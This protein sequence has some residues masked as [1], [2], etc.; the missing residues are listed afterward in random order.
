MLCFLSVLVFF[1][2]WITKS[3]SPWSLPSSTSCLW[4]YLLQ[5]QD[6]RALQLVNWNTTIPS[7]TVHLSNSQ[8]PLQVHMKVK[9]I[10]WPPNHIR[11]SNAFPYRCE[12]KSLRHKVKDFAENSCLYIVKQKYCK[13]ETVQVSL[14]DRTILLLI[15]K[16]SVYKEWAK[17]AKRSCF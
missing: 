9:V 15:Y 7:S 13:A 8:G 1:L 16:S 17:A 14:H 12:D 3:C 10:L 6:H 5:R 2:E 4:E 11:N